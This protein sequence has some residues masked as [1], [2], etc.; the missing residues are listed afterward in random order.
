MKRFLAIAWL[1]IL[2]PFAAMT[3]MP[4]AQAQGLSLA[5]DIIADPA[6]GAALLG[7]DPVAYFIDNRAVRGDRER[8]TTFAG[9]VW[10]FASSANK[11]AFQANPDIYLPAFGGYDPIAI[12]SGIAV[13]GSPEFFVIDNTRVFLFRNTETREAFL[14]APDILQSAAHHWPQVKRDMVP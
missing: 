5:N 3:A 1:A 13:F 7:Y 12:A 4:T 14:R 6:T 11:S 9:K 10:Y 8:Q 2:T